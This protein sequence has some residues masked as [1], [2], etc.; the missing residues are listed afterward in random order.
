LSS[1]HPLIASAIQLGVPAAVNGSPQLLEHPRPE[2][3]HRDQLGFMKQGLR[4]LARFSAG[5]LFC[6]SLAAAAQPTADPSDPAAR[7]HR[8][9]KSEEIVS[10]SAGLGEQVEGLGDQVAELRSSVGTQAE[11]LV[12]LV[13]ALEVLLPGIS[14]GAAPTLEEAARQACEREIAQLNARLQQQ[15]LTVDE[16]QRRA[17]KAEKLA[18]ALDEA[19]ARAKTEIERLTN[20]LATARARQAEALQQAVQL[21]RQLA[22]AEA[23]L[24][25]DPEVESSGSTAEATRSTSSQVDGPDVGLA[26]VSDETGTPEPTAAKVLPSAVFYQVRPDDT[27]SSISERVYGDVAAWE[28]IY[29]ANRDILSSP[30][31]LQPGM[32]LVIP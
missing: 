4:G 15:Q 25:R 23:R 27:L 31:A 10:D 1:S 20:A 19:E 29:E 28:R 9:L 24:R 14:S 12:R 17:E 30:D 6:L 32:S 11:L 22:K 18:A 13:G 5:L 21:E 8:A 2:I 7:S 26:A 3:A 16:A